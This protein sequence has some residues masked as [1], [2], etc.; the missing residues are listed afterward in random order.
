MSEIKN[1]DWSLQLPFCTYNL[2]GHGIDI[3]RN[4][5]CEGICQ[6]EFPQRAKHVQLFYKRKIGRFFLSIHTDWLSTKLRGRGFSLIGSNFVKYW[7]LEAVVQWKLLHPNSF[8]SQ[9]IYRD[10]K[11]INGKI[12]RSSEMPHHHFKRYRRL[13]CGSYCMK[14]FYYQHER[15]C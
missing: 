15:N 11:S 12:F 2:S 14:E 9:L 8:E 4:G 5:W 7:I 3:F 1:Q 13:I 6:P 10:V